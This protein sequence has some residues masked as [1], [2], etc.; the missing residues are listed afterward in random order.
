MSKNTNELKTRAPGRFELDV[1]TLGSPMEARILAS[2]MQ[3]PLIAGS[4]TYGVKESVSV[5]PY[6]PSWAHS[7]ARSIPD[8]VA[9]RRAIP[10]TA[11][12]TSPRHLSAAPSTTPA[13]TP[14]RN[15]AMGLP[16]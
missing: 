4:F 12:T 13:A 7:T 3:R 2:D 10:T 11:S 8:M 1:S 15:I 6:L 5:A 16:T 14:A 9:R